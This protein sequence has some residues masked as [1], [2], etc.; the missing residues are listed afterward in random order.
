MKRFWVDDAVENECR[1]LRLHGVIDEHAD[2]SFFASLEGRVQVDLAQVERV[3]SFGIRAWIDAVRKV[4][5]EVALEFVA[6]H[7]T[8]VDRISMVGGFFDRGTI[9]SFHAPMRC[10]ACGVEADVLLTAAA[11]RE[12]GGRLPSTACAG[13][14]RPMQL[15]GFE[16][17]YLAL[18][19]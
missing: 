11:C 12:A 13:C 1:V 9:V 19:G 7:P 4:G 17:A 10:E 5:H 18:I 14:G 16:D 3:N 6:L 8:L 15:D 2:L